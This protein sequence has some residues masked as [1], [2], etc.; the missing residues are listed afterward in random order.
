MIT[1]QGNLR[2]GHSLWQQMRAP[3]VPYAALTRDVRTDVLIVGGG[4]SGAMIA[5]ELARAGLETVV[6]DRRRPP[7]GSTAASTALVQYEIDTPL[8]ELRRKIGEAN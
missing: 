2:T 7:Q 3:R 8:V 5:E 6:V 1:A 4:I